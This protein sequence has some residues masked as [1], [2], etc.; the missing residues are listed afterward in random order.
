MVSSKDDQLTEYLSAIS[1]TSMPW[2]LETHFNS[3]W[4]WL[5][6][7]E[8]IFGNLNCESKNIEVL[9]NTLKIIRFKAT[10]DCIT[11]NFFP[12]YNVNLI[13]YKISDWNKL[14][15]KLF[16]YERPTFLPASPSMS[17]FLLKISFLYL[18]I[19]IF[20]HKWLFLIWLRI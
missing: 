9:L 16:R 3:T 10:G 11:Q 13:F 18:R 1:L 5:L 14:Y 17:F 15:G 2:C 20:K 4:W 8:N 6:S 7:I 19:L 12:D